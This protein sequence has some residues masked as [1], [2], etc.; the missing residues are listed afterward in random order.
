V[1][2]LSEEELNAL[3]EEATIDAY[4]DDEQLSGFAVMIE[5]NLEMPFETM[6]LGVT[7]TVT[8]VSQTESGI[9]ADC[10]REGN[11]QAISILDLPL[12]EPPPE[13]TEWIAAYRHWARYA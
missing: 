13:G 9:V 3:V 7:V 1:P 8:G 5:D 10:V 4:G 11:H 12:P 6:V 2:E